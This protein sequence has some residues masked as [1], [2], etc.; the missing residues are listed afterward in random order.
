M[1][2]Y[3]QHRYATGFEPIYTPCPFYVSK[4]YEE[5][6]IGVEPDN[7]SNESILSMYMGYN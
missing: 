6:E 4:S 7:F 1:I 3:E 5:L 2:D